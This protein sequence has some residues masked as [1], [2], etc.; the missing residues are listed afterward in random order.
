MM[1]FQSLQD[2]LREH[3]RARIRRGELTGSGLARAAGFP[4]GHLSNFL[5]GRRGL[6][7]ESMDR[8][9]HTLDVRILDLIGLDEIRSRF[10]PAQARNG[11]EQVA[12]VAM[13]KATQARFTP[14][15][16]LETRCFERSFLRRLRARNDDDRSD[17]L[18]FVLIRLA[19]RTARELFPCEFTAAT[20]LVDRHYTSLEPYRRAQPNL[21]AVRFAGRCLTGYLSLLHN[22][23][24]L[25]TRDPRHEPQSV[26]IAH[27]RS[28][29]QYIIGRVCHVELEV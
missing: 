18:R 8:L 14:E 24:V 10:I 2:Q 25:R 13:E 15:H 28:Y 22:D 23:L 5:N 9:L 6:S 3:I 7:L 1:S 26:T 17:W 12:V 4:Q 20:I 19:V 21:Y 27:G 29:S 11:L 16:I